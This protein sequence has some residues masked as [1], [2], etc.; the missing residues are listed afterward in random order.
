MYGHRTLAVKATTA[1]LQSL[2]L[3]KDIWSS[4]VKTHVNPEIKIKGSQIQKLIRSYAHILQHYKN[5]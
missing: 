1:P 4:L 2:L 5:Q 3:H